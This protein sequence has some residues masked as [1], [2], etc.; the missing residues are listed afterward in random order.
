MKE[1]MPYL[2]RYLDFCA[3]AFKY[4]MD[5]FS[6]SWMYYWLLVPA[7]VYFVFFV[8]KW[9]AITLPFWISFKMVFNSFQIKVKNK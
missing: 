7:T 4:D 3:E 9:V 1:I 2:L 5:V 6:Q 8:L